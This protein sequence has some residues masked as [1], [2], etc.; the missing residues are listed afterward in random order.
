MNPASGG[1]SEG[2]RN[3]IPE[4]KKHGITNEVVCFNNPNESFIINSD[5]K[6]YALGNGKTKWSYNQ[7]F[8]KWLELNYINYNIIIVHGL[9]LYQNY[10]L[11][12]FL[13]K[14]ES[15]SKR[16]EIIV[17]CMPHGML[18]PYFQKSKERKLKALRNRIYWE[19]IESKFIKNINA[20]IFTTKNE[21][22]LA[23]TTFKNYHPKKCI[24]AGY[25]IKE[26]GA[27]KNTLNTNN[28]LLFLGRIDPKKGLD[29]LLKAYD[30]I[31]KE[32]K[33]KLPQLQVA[34][35]IQDEGYY[36]LCLEIISKNP[37]LKELVKWNNF[38]QGEEKIKLI[39]GCDAFILPSHQ[40]NFGISVVEALSLSKP[41]LISNKININETI[42]VEF[43]GFVEE[44]TL[45]GCIRLLNKYYSLNM[46]QKKKMAINSKNTFLKHY[47]IENYANNLQKQIQLLL[48]E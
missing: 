22:Q 19:L 44:D 17:C 7:E 32:G 4:L 31:I 25:G 21:M 15:E 16:N 24:M 13:K 18:D 33:I 27:T 8:S 41:V 20:L 3:I 23:Q 36:K 14:L 12:K 34:G 29:L 30:F 37:E 48:A 39:D 46:N 6:I 11:N 1:P 2:I 9:W 10:A 45:D 43:C 28:Y 47:S 5:F 40:E 42:K 38:V 26:T 35:P